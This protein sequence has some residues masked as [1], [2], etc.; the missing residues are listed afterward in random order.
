MIFRINDACIPL[1]IINDDDKGRQFSN[2]ASFDYVLFLFSKK[3]EYT[4]FL[5]DVKKIQNIILLLQLDRSTPDFGAF[6][7]LSEHAFLIN[8]ILDKQKISK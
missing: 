2:S 8:C 1:S 5:V 3:N 4:F 7:P 6:I